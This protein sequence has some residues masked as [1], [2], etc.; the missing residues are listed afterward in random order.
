MALGPI[1]RF[2][3]RVV[4]ADINHSRLWAERLNLS[5]EA[6]MELKFWLDSVDFLTRKAIWFSSGA[7][8]IAYSDAS[9]TGYGGYVAELGNDVAH[10]LLIMMRVYGGN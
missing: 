8:Q 5:P 3:T 4:Y 2:R 6:Q 9:T 10:G 7:T 1:T